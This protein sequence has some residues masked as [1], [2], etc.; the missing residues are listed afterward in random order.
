MKS[1]EKVNAVIEFK[2]NGNI[3]VDFDDEYG[4]DFLYTGPNPSPDSRPNVNAKDEW[5]S[6]WENI[7]VS[8]LGEVKEFPL[9][10]WVN[11]SDLHIPDIKDHN[12][13]IGVES[14]DDKVRDLFLVGFGISIYERIHFIRGLENTWIDIHENR[15]ELNWLLDILTDMNLYCIEKY[16]KAG[17]DGFITCDD[18]GLQDRLMINPT[19]FREIWKS[20]YAKIYETAHKAGLKTF[21]HSCGYITEIL[22]D[23][24]EIG[25]DVIQMDQQE[26][27]GLDKLSKRFAGRITFFNPVDIQAVLPYAT[28]YLQ[29]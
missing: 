24:I 11:K 14:I 23:L 3:A 12:R 27:M 21:L 5:G 10:D 9:I 4:S 16:R 13:W 28:E 15:D 20:H 29:D 19:H 18:W 22:D 1:K 26:N 8:Q 7:G 2:S 6:I 17:L 25:L